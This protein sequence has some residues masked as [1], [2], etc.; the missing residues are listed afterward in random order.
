MLD[1]LKAIW[2]FVSEM[3]FAGKSL[4]EV[5]LANKFLTFLIVLLA[6]S[7]SLNYFSLGKIYDL[8]LARREENSKQGTSKPPLGKTPVLEPL[9]PASSASSPTSDQEREEQLRKKLKD[10]FKD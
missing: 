10:I 3:F 9:P 4:K 2:P 6:M 1:L 7:L 8:A 5:V